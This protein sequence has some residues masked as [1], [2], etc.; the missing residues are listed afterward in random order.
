MKLEI[1]TFILKYFF[2][3]KFI[4]VI[5]PDEKFILYIMPPVVPQIVP[6]IKDDIKICFFMNDNSGIKDV[7]LTNNGYAN[8]DII[9]LVVVSFFNRIKLIIREIT[10]II[11][12]IKDGFSF[13]IY[14]I[15]IAKPCVPPVTRFKVFK[16][17]LKLI[18]ANSKHIINSKYFFIIH[19]LL[20]V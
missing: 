15:T 18:A 7:I 16:N 13:I 11:K 9:A 3:N 19:L 10:F 8:V 20:L 17:K 5:P 4:I 6:A 2:S 12:I 14:F 1:D